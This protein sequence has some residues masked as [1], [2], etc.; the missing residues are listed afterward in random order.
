MAHISTGS[1]RPGVELAAAASAEGVPDTLAKGARLRPATARARHVTRVPM[2]LLS[3]ARRVPRRPYSLGTRHAE[4]TIRQAQARA[5]AASADSAVSA[6]GVPSRATAPL[7][8][9]ADDDAPRDASDA[10]HARVGAHATADV[11]DERD[12]GLR[13]RRQPLARRRPRGRRS[14]PRGRRHRRAQT[15]R[16]QERQRTPARPRTR[17]QT[18]NAS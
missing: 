8:G 17:E 4:V 13:G 12:G 1:R 15:G 11:D 6:G 16:T 18:C 3:R 9:D 2:T 5:L 10:P 7:D 14:A